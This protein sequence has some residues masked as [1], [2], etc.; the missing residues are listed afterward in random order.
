M[1]IITERDQIKSAIAS[2]IKKWGNGTYPVDKRGIQVGYE[3]SKLNINTC[4]S[5]EVDT[6]IGNNSWTSNICN[7]CGNR[8][9]DVVRVGEEP[10]YESKT[11]YLCKDCLTKAYNLFINRELL[12]KA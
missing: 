3:L 5:E 10:D 2:F 9:K 12:D 11:S 4:T 1:Q 8:V 7:E 6:L